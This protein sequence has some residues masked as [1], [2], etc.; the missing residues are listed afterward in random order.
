MGNNWL[1]LQCPVADDGT[2]MVMSRIDFAALQGY[3][4]ASQTGWPNACQYGGYNTPC[5]WDPIAPCCFI[6]GPTCAA[7]N[8]H[9]QSC[10]STNTMSARHP[11][12]R[13]APRPR[14]GATRCANPRAPQNAS[15]ARATPGLRP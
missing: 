11:A 9:V 13:A 3:T 12:P 2:Q 10:T 1:S 8:Y 14:R 6:A 5:P 4:N 15:P 7:A